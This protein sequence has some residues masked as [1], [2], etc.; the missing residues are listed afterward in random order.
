[1]GIGQTDSNLIRKWEH[2]HLLDYLPEREA[3]LVARNVDN[4]VR[5][6]EENKKN[7]NQ[8]QAGLLIP[9]VVF[10]EHII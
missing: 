7:L 8:H 3:Y 10:I 5:F 2:T 4:T 1:M 6:I 9:V